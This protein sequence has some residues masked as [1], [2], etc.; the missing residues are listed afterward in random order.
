MVEPSSAGVLR[1]SDGRLELTVPAGAVTSTTTIRYQ[2]QPVRP[3]AGYQHAGGFFTLTAV[4]AAGHPVRHFQRD[5]SLRVAYEA[6]AD[7][8]EDR[9]RLHFYD[10]TLQHWVALPTTVNV[11]QHSLTARTNH[12]T[13]FGPLSNS[14]TSC[15]EIDWTD[16]PAPLRTSFAQ[17]CARIGL[18]TLGDPVG[19]PFQRGAVW[20]QRF[21]SGALVSRPDPLG[22]FYMASPLADAYLNESAAKRA[23]VGAPSADS[24]TT[25]PETY[26]D[27]F[28]D[29][30]GRPFIQLERG[31]VAQN[32]R[33]G[34][35]RVHFRFPEF[36]TVT[37]HSEWE[38]REDEDGRT[39]TE[40]RLTLRAELDP[41][42]D[43]DG[44]TAEAQLFVTFDDGTTWQPRQT[45]SAG[46]VEF[47]YNQ[48]LPLTRTFSFHWAL[49]RSAHSATDDL[50]GY[51]PC[52]YYDH[53]QEYTGFGVA[54]GE[55]PLTVSCQ[56]GGGP[57]GG[58]FVPPTIRFVEVW[59]DGQGNLSIKAEIT[60][61]SGRI[62]SA[63]IA[64]GPGRLAP[65]LTPTPDFGPN[66][67][68][69]VFRDVPR[70]Q[71]V[72]FTITASDPSGNTAS[73]SGNSR[74][75][76][77][78]RNGT[79]CI[80]PC[81][82]YEVG[83]GNPVLPGLGNKVETL[84]VVFVAGPGEADI[85]LTLT[86]NAQ[87]PTVGLTGQGWSFPYQASATR[88]DNLLLQ[89]YEVIY[90][91]GRQVLFAEAEDGR[92]VSRTPDVHDRL[93]QRGA[94]LVLIT[95]QLLEY[96]FDQA[97][98]LIAQ[99]DRNG[100]AL[101]FAYSG[102]QLTS[103]SSAA[104]RTITLSYNSQ[105]LIDSITAPEGKQFRF[106]YAETR[107][108][109]FTDARGHVTTFTY[110]EQ[111]LGTLLDVD[112]Q[113]YEATDAYLASVYTPEGHF[114]N[115]QTYDD[116]GRVVE[117]TV[118]ER[119]RRTFVYDDDARTTTITDAL[120]HVTVY[121]YDELYRLVQI[122]Y[123][124]G[125][126]EFFTY[127]DNFNRTSFIDA[128][129]REYT[130]TY[131]DRGNRLTETG[132][133]G[134]SRAWAFNDRDQVT[135]FTD[136]EGRVTRYAYDARGNLV[137]LTNAAGDS[138]TLTYDSRGLPIEI[139]DFNGNQ[140]TNGYDA[141]TGD[142]LSSTNA[143]GDQVQFAYDGLGRLQ[144]STNGRG[145]A[146]RYTFD[147][148]DNLLQLDGP[149]GFQVRYRYDKNDN[150]IA[151][152]NA[153]G[154]E[155]RLVY[156]QSENL[157]EEHTPLGLRTGYAYDAMNNLVRVEDAE[158]RVWNFAYDAVYN[159]VAEHGPEESHTFYRYDAVGNLTALVRC[160]S[161][162]VGEI[163]A[164]QQVQALVYDDLNRVVSAIANAVPDAPASAD[165][166]VATHFAYDA[167][168]NLVAL[169]D[170]NGRTTT[171]GY[172]AL[173][174][175]V[176]E[177]T[178]A[179][180]VS[181]YGYDAMSNLVSMT[182]P[183]GFTSTFGYDAA[184][185]LVSV[186]DAL[187]QTTQFSYDANSN[188]VAQRD[189][190]GI[191]TAYRYDALDRLEELVQNERSDASTSSTQNVTT[192]FAYDLAG[193][194]RFVY[195]PRGTY[196]T[197]HQYDADLRRVQTLDAEG[198]VTSLSYDRVNNLVAVTDANGHTTTS[199]YD[200]LN[201]IVQITN[202][203]GHAVHFA[204]DQLD[205]LISLSDARGFTSTYEYDGL[206]RVVRFTDN[207]DGIWRYTYDPVSLLL[208]ETDANGHT[209]NFTY[210][211]VYRLLS[212]TDAEGYVT[213][214]SYDANNNPLT[215]TDGNGHTATSTYDELDRLATRTNAED[216]TT[217]YRYNWLGGQ[218]AMIE[219][220]GIVT[221]YGYDPLYRLSSVT[222]NQQPDQPATVDTNVTTRYRYDATGNLVEIRDANG[223][224]TFFAF[225][226]LNRLTREVDA[227]GHQWD[228]AYDKTFNRVERLD[229]LRN[230]TR[231]SY[232]PDDQLARID[233]HD[234]T[235][236]THS[237]DEN[238]NLLNVTNHLGSIER[239]YD[240]LN[241]LV[242]EQDVHGRQT[243][244]GYDAVGNRLSLTYPDGR[245]VTSSY[246]KNNWLAST[247]DPD[248]RT[249][250]YV[251]DG[252][253]NVVRQENPNSTVVTQSYDK[254]NRLLSI[255][256]RQ[257]GGANTVNSRFVYTYDEVGQ[258]VTM[259]AT[260][261]WR[262]PSVVTSSYRYD[263]LRRLVR[264][265]DS[266]G[267]W[268]DYSFDAV[269]NR[270]TL[271]T[272][273]NSD[274][275]RPLDSK[276][277]H[278][279]YN[280]T[281]QLLTVVGDTHPG[282]PGLKRADNS[283]QALHAFRHEVAAQ[284]YKGISGD[285]ASD[286]LAR[287]D[288]LLAQ[289]YGTPAPNAAA[290]ESA[291]NTLR[292]Q[293]EAYL[294]EGDLRNQGVATSL[295]AKLRL[296][297][298]ANNGTSGEL[299]TVTY[300]YDANGNR[301]NKEFPGPQGPRIQGSDYH[302]DPENRLVTVQDYQQNLQ[303][304]R[305]ERALSS[306]DHDGNGRRVIKEYD[307]KTGGGGTKRVEYVYDGLDPIAEYN[308]WNPQY[309]NFYR[310]D[311]GRILQMHHFPSGTQGQIFWYHYDGLGSVAGLT[312]HQGQSS[313][314]YRYEAYGKIELPKGNFSDPHN[315]YSFTGQEWNEHT[316]LYEFYA[317]HY[318]PDTGTWMSQDSY[319][320]QIISPKTLHRYGYVGGDPVN[321]ID[322]Y[323]Y[324]FGYDIPFVSWEGLRKL[325]KVE[326]ISETSL[327]YA[328]VAESGVSALMRQRTKTLDQSA[329]D[330]IR[331]DPAMIDYEKKILE[332]IK[333]DSR[334]CNGE[335]F[336]YH[337][338]G[339]VKFGGNTAPV[340]FSEQARNPLKGI[341]KV[342]PFDSQSLNNM[343]YID[344]WR[345]ASSE[346]TWLLRNS[347]VITNVDVDS[348]GNITISYQLVDVL[349]LRPS[350]GR[351]SEYNMITKIT[352]TT[353]HDLLGATEMKIEANWKSEY[354]K[355]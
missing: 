71:I 166:N 12:F 26:H 110:E 275:N 324:L 250:R 197:E 37:V 144:S 74:I 33:S 78:G 237:Y 57:G 240:P 348:Q 45:V 129:G 162:L 214:W 264:D 272:N 338:I 234:G 55:Y 314:N 323:G 60:D 17:A 68:N 147:G 175:L 261:A 210:D 59:P 207:A 100:N 322:Y 274:T 39:V 148:N 128:L 164:V 50:I 14:L 241:R 186:T 211:I 151:A 354:R 300:S 212:R 108:V 249:T 64:G 36:E 301:I 277:L 313:H 267:I 19:A 199:R 287:A 349:D 105:G 278:Y 137:G 140:T 334:Y 247:S 139:T 34:N 184:N 85:D 96:E 181:R 91:D 213:S 239:S 16:L 41:A 343:D 5:L 84:P 227:L 342:N 303:G 296:A 79:G 24:T 320:G 73:A 89:G 242:E 224:P 109:A 133:L 153:N 218:V 316:G 266:R 134:W 257:I 340:T 190:E 72:N 40:A 293:I 44:V 23:A 81:V 168:G 125:T 67:Y 245:I 178:A 352:G 229:A 253:G 49:H 43:A 90:P 231:Y 244:F 182:N 318:D 307:P 269:G 53:Q 54:R 165:T 355:E 350:E 315:H 169:T 20:V 201:R 336:N 262:N 204:Y 124:D 13:L 344:T 18:G 143:A 119:E 220:D 161:P 1:S 155:S 42:P 329:I 284:Q 61:N 333:N 259:E 238:N 202:P 310:G 309:E 145:F 279:S 260:Y 150:L 2:A 86:Y 93:E 87:D 248:G 206:D 335:E 200:D 330:K 221:G 75:T 94:T 251:R 88:R 302:Y 288:A 122:T 265:E 92:L 98:R 135:Q 230:R 217:A 131:D 208:A 232:Y 327:P 311:Q 219:A 243:A 286:L 6:H 291:L 347:T 160:N 235:F 331:K 4:D 58:D 104:G 99:R 163:C 76:F 130:Y 80:D 115:Q 189:P 177:E 295:I 136:A 123:A 149:L 353:W 117:Q 273:D 195:D 63:T 263:P 341:F 337:E 156:D 280:A 126:A 222:F 138:S 174:R 97:G 194:L 281:N 172:D 141:T 11:A 328:D 31:F 159:R 146:T 30:R 7:L 46:E 254:A 9:L 289:L 56:G 282:S 312:K 304:N 203:E 308:T 188:L 167:V 268:T 193:N 70:G 258:R 102:D 351:V 66:I 116:R 157:I 32:D 29:F 82:G 299:Q 256:N 152:T 111:Y 183:R 113:P 77:R 112:G 118:G 179:A 176:R 305:V 158:G 3:V 326:K 83:V 52:L 332:M 226:G 48:L 142:L 294:A 173:D 252:V 271:T 121:H 180:Q 196:V 65:E 191:V 319:R 185:R 233:Y 276:T 285:A 198:G 170:A 346:L 171:F 290:V 209:T 215:R 15:S 25:A 62:A 246:L 35:T 106:D 339:L 216:E 298:A 187:Q 51:A 95:K 292:S 28:H 297:G 205:N 270:L 154:G 127:D 132:P 317:R 236:V 22:A 38:Q 120:G 228:Y 223:N 225:D 321:T 21:A 69:A 192:R 27:E 101:L 283:A 114:K 47:T 10:E 8:H 107:L 306:M 103:I 255:E 345:V 325:V